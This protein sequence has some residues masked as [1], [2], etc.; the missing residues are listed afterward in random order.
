HTL[1]EQDYDL[2]DTERLLKI[3]KPVRKVKAILCGH[4]HEYSYHADDDL[5]I[6]YLPA[7]GYAYNEP[8]GWLDAVFRKEGADFTLRAIGG[9]MSQNGKTRSLR[10]RA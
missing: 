4:G 1:G 10:W 9:D 3:V 8:V 2:M 5:H 6:I 7:L